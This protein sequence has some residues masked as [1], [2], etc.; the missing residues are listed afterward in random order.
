MKPLWPFFTFLICSFTTTRTSCSVEAK[1]TEVKSYQFPHLQCNSKNEELFDKSECRKVYWNQTYRQQCESI[2]AYHVQGKYQ[3]DC[4]YNYHHYNSSASLKAYQKKKLLNSPKHRKIR[5]GGFNMLHPGSEKTLFKDFELLALIIDN[6]FDL[7]TGFELIPVNSKQFQH[8][9][10]ISVYILYYQEALKALELNQ[11]LSKEKKR[12]QKLKITEDIKRAKLSYILPGY[13][14][15]LKRLRKRDPHWA[16]L[17]SPRAESSKY[18]H[19]KEF[20]GHYYRASV[21]RVATNTFCSQEV[22]KAKGAQYL[23][24]P[25]ACIPSFDKKINQ[26]FSRKPF[27]A[28]FESGHFRFTLIASHVIFNSPNPHNFPK[29]MADILRPSFQVDSYKSLPTGWGIN[30]KN[31]ARWAEVKLTLGLMDT[32]RREY[33]SKN[34]IYLADFNLEKKE[35]L[36]DDILSSSFPGGQVYVGDPTSLSPY[37]GHSKSYDHFIFDPT[38]TV[39]CVQE[40]GSVDSGHI[41]FFTTD[42]IT[43]RVGRRDY[44]ELIWKNFMAEF[45]NRYQVSGITQ[46]KQNKSLYLIKS[47]PKLKD[48]SIKKDKYEKKFQ[49]KLLNPNPKFD[50]LY[51]RYIQVLSDHL[52]TYLKCRTH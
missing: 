46:D 8:N 30:A 7:L 42:Y 29:K 37:K 35:P 41:D 13:L 16:L 12:Q 23:G 14:K 26:A 22:S 19:Q 52:P 33:G 39:R 40:K 50:T 49:K 34:I 6:E 38:Q 25:F 44:S 15:I 3:V 31:Y 11:K 36:W 27:I 51:Y 28:D 21:V 10:R 18:W 32:M 4:H 47:P 24:T 2:A 5:L 45:D 20:I 1:V 17:M 9:N 48:Y 43:E